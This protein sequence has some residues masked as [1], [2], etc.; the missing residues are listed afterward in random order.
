MGN[1]KTDLVVVQ[2]NLNVQHCVNLLNINLPFMQNSGPGLTF[3]DDNT[4]PHTALTTANFLAQNNVN[5]LPWLALSPDMN[6]IEHIWDELGRRVRTNHQI[7]NVQDLTRALQLEWQALPN[8]LIR[9]YVN[10]MRQRICA[11]IASN[12][13]HTRY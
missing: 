6:P 8:V 12:G 1:I 4:R 5:V 3:Q 7:N 10:S 11:C 13:G 2:G 9:R